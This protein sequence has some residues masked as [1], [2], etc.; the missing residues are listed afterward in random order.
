MCVLDN[1]IILESRVMLA[2]SG[3]VF[4]CPGAQLF[5]RCSTNLRF[6]EWNV[7]ISRSD[8][9][10]QWITPVTELEIHLIIREHVFNITRTS[11][12]DSLPLIST[13]TVATAVADLNATKIKCTEIKTSDDKNS[14]V[15]TI[16]INS[17]R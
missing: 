8:S 12:Y 6:L 5:F 2:P 1:I 16:N 13:F 9:K 17:S 7:I 4:V 14:S 11:A 3:E 15:A 10:S